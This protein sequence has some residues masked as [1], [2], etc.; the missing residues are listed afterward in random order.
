MGIVG[1]LSGILGGLSRI[2]WNVVLPEP[3]WPLLHGPLMVCGFVGVVI[4]LERA[5][6]HGA[7][8]AYAVPATAG[9]GTMGLASGMPVAACAWLFAVASGGL[10]CLLANLTRRGPAFFTMVMAAGALAWLIGNAVWLSGFPISRTVTWWQAFLLLTIAGERL[11]LARLRNLSSGLWTGV[12]TALC[13]TMGLASVPWEPVVGSVLLGL[14]MVGLAFWLFTMDVARR[15]VR[16]AGLPRFIAIC[17]LS[18]YAWLFVAGL[19]TAMASGVGAGPRYD[20]VQHA[21]FLGF[22]FAMIFGH[23]PVIFPA[24]LGGL[25]RYTP[26]F[27]AHVVLLH[28]S[29]M[30]R[31]ASDVALWPA[32]RQIGGA[33]NAAAIVLFLGNMVW[34]LVETRETALENRQRFDVRA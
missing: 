32:G 7:W 21:F 33:L 3:A 25:V 27:Y 34:S 14:G 6:A 9:M 26:R 29:L 28:L 30:V 2:G 24:I 15:T 23:A 11:E 8:W 17:L 12:A 18:G 31:V 16:Q 4:S 10:V 13:Y 5:V 20:L 22:V 19:A 1:L